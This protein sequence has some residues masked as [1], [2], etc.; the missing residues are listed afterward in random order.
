MSNK[1]F[2]PIYL[3]RNSRQSHSRGYGRP[4]TRSPFPN[5]SFTSGEPSSQQFGQIICIGN[6][7]LQGPAETKETA[8]HKEK[9]NVVF[10]FRR[11]IGILPQ[12]PKSR[13][14]QQY[15]ASITRNDA[16]DKCL[17]S[18]AKNADNSESMDIESSYR[19]TFYNPKERSNNSKK[20]NSQERPLY[21]NVEERKNGRAYEQFMKIFLK[22]EL[23]I[24]QIFN[25]NNNGIKRSPM[26]YGRGCY[27]SSLGA[28]GFSREKNLPECFTNVKFTQRKQHSRI[29]S[30]E[31]IVH[32]RDYAKN[33]N[34]L[35]GTKQ[36]QI[37]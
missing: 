7:A 32:S 24:N 8:V 23:Q 30:R 6:K 27:K 16:T 34:T 19:L 21:G 22:K 29:G 13:P 28:R 17:S 31:A 4:K 11:G 18:N 3:A 37:L 12:K 2:S 20:E 25:S 1:L 10:P 5:N 35:C 36:L 9:N 26:L 33:S 15:L 14:A